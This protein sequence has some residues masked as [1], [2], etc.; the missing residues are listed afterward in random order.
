ME[1]LQFKDYFGIST[2][3]QL[4]LVLPSCYGEQTINNEKL[5]CIE[6]EMEAHK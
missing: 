1:Q 2:A 5:K 3:E 6:E 4:Q